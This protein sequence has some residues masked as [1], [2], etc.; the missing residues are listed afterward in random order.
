MSTYVKQTW[1]DSE[2]PINAARLGHIEDGIEAAHNAINELSEEL[3]SVQDGE[4]GGYY[5]V[6]VEQAASN[7]MRVHYDPSKTDM[8]EVSSQDIVIPAG[9]TGPKGADGTSVTVTSVSQ[10][11]DDG[12]SN[13]ITFSDG[14]SMTVKNGKTGSQ[15]KPG[16]DGIDGSN[17]MPGEDGKDG[18]SATH[19]W[20]G[21]TLTITSASGTSS[22][23]LKGEKGDTGATGGTGPAG[24]DGSNGKDGVSATHSWSGTTLTVTSA[25]G[26]SSANLKGEKGDKGDTGSAGTNATITGATATVDA[27]TGTPSV[28]V[29]PGGTASA[30]TFA[31]AF[32]NLKGAKGDTGATGAT[33]ATG[34]QGPKPVKGVDYWTPADQESIVQD[35][36]AALGTPVFGRVDTSNNI[37]LTGEL[38]DGTYTIKY[39]DAEGNVTEIGTLNHTYEPEPTYHNVLHDAINTNGTPYIGDYGEVGYKT[40]YRIKSDGSDYPNASTCLTGYIPITNVRDTFYLSGIELKSSD[41]GHTAV[42]I[43]DSNFGQIHKGTIKAFYQEK[44]NEYLDASVSFTSDGNLISTSAYALKYW[45]GADKANTAAYIRFCGQSITNSSVITVN[46]PIE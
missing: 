38:A 42:Y 31:F 46:E 33:G 26:T 28:T 21:T 44:D 39:E 14:N 1:V 5:S 13:V 35:V 8:P 36:I 16:K 6:R 10:S 41:D 17:G 40:G 19:S 20:N 43:Y 30:R 12:G 2:T 22:A 25:S 3:D 11:V 37:I 34:S 32:K 29:T 23:N 4:D 7:V 45:I 27:N 15:G 18:V 9:P 24:K